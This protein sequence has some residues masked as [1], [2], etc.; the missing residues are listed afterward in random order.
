[1]KVI[2]KFMG[3]LAQEFL[4]GNPKAEITL[5]FP[6]GTC[7]KDVFDRYNIPVSKGYTAL[8]NHRVA[9]PDELLKDGMVVVFF[10]AAY[11]G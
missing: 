9:K 6:S 4:G 7:I 1:M 5:E 2:V 3:T 10:H 8:I 11:G